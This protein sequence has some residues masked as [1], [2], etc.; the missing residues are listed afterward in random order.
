MN[1]KVAGYFSAAI[2]GTGGILGVPTKKDRWVD[3][4]NNKAR[5][6]LIKD[7]HTFPDDLKKQEAPPLCFYYDTH[8]Q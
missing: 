3:L 1:I 7:E 4:K 6:D 2:F 5:F 8:K